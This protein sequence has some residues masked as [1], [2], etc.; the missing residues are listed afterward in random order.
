MALLFGSL[1]LQLPSAVMYSLA[2]WA[3]AQ[4]MCQ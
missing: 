1:C 2:Q 4:K 3:Y